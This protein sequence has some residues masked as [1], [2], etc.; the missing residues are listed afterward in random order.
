MARMVGLC[1]IWAIGIF[2]VLMTLS[3]LEDS[4]DNLLASFSSWVLASLAFQHVLQALI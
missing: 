2:G 4:V 3:G 1:Y